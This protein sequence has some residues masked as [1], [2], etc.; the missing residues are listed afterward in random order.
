MSD[1]I[2][3]VDTSHLLYRV[4]YET[5]GNRSTLTA[6]QQAD[7][8]DKAI[9]KLS[10]YDNTLKPKT[11][12]TAFDDSTSWRTDYSEK[13]G[14]RP[15]NGNKNRNLTA[16]EARLKKSFNKFRTATRDR[17]SGMSKFTV[18][19]GKGLESDDLL[20][21]LAHNKSKA[22]KLSIISL[23]H[24][25]GQLMKYSNTKV[26]DMSKSIVRQVSWFKRNSMTAVRK[27]VKDANLERTLRGRH[28][29]N[30]LSVFSNLSQD[31]FSRAANG[32]LGDVLDELNP[33]NDSGM[34]SR[35]RFEHNSV[36][37]NMD[38][39]PNKIRKQV[40]R[41]VSPTLRK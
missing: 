18:L 36:L 23:D 13:N 9:K 41:I 11:M 30:V 37:L 3:A 8:I 15:Y 12:V 2:V 24:D 38:M 21:G 22:T 34:S 40:K 27:Y 6:T 33:N 4:F 28:A 10:Y 17:L 35:T 31:D 20:A 5:I 19:H 26:F 1:H 29:Y 16:K 7:A 14:L 25:I 32:Q 39:Q